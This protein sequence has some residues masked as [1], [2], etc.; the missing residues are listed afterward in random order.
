MVGPG[1]QGDSRAPP[2]GFPPPGRAWMARHQTPVVIRCILER[3]TN[4]SMGAEIDNVVEFEELGPEQRRP[5]PD[6]RWPCSIDVFLIGTRMPVS[7][8][9]ACCSPRCPSSIASE[10]RPEPALKPWSS[11][12]PYAHGQGDQGRLDAPACRSCCTTCPR[13][14]GMPAGAA[15]PPTQRVDEFPCR[16][17]PRP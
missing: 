8:A 14:T 10:R 7:P 2:R 17:W 4:I 11:S 3:V 5:C 12:S 9:S 16:A 15:S 6:T 1:P 13:A